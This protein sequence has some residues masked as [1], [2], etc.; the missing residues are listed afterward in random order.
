MRIKNNLFIILIFILSMDFAFAKNL[1]ARMIMEK[2]H[3]VDNGSSLEQ[4]M[5]MLLINKHG[6]V[7]KKLLKVYQKDYGKDIYKIMFFK[8]PQDVKNTAFLTLD[9]H[10]SKKEDEQRIYLP[11]IKKVKRIPS[12]DKSSSF[13]GSD[14]TYY[15]LLKY[16]LDNYKFKLLKEDKINGYEAWFIQSTPINR[17]EKE[18]SGYDKSIDI[19]RKDNNIVI[20][21]IK[22]LTNSK[23]KKFYSVHKMH[24]ENNIWILD[25][26]SM[27]TKKNQKTLHK[28]IFKLKNTKINIHINDDMFSIRQLEKGI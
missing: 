22:F 21:S 24:Q 18:E 20:H 26:I 1:S 17:K 3:A 14:F 12:S 19:V 2:V 6:Q 23:K 8:F 27:E 15:D 7:R 10:S 25:E 13:M 4:D 5:L 16:D 28:T 11:A 9:Y